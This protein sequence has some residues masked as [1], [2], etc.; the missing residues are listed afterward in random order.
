MK[1]WWKEYIKRGTT[2]ELLDAIY[3][4]DN[5]NNPDNLEEEFV[6]MIKKELVNNRYPFKIIKME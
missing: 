3:W 2:S 1:D 6:I 5:G 4:Y